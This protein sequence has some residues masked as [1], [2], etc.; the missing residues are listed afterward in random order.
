MSI[1][2]FAVT[3]QWAIIPLREVSR[4]VYTEDE[5]A[6]IVTE[7]CGEVEYSRHCEAHHDIYFRTMYL[8]P[9]GEPDKN[10]VFMTLQE[11]KDWA[12]SHIKTDM[13]SKRRE[14]RQLQ[15]KLEKLEE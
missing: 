8:T 1:M 12:S 11:A 5:I 2:C 3:D 10:T 13:V 9:E 6:V 15:T 7:I 4:T 14:L